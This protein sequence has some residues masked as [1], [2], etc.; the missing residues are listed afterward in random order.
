MFVARSP[1]GL[2]GAAVL[3]GLILAGPSRAQP[4]NLTPP[5]VQANGDQIC[6]GGRLDSERLAN[7][8]FYNHSDIA[9]NFK[10]ADDLRG[11]FRA[12]E[13][14]TG[15]RR[16]IVD[17]IITMT[18]TMVVQL[19][20]EFQPNVDLAAGDDTR[21]QQSIA[22][23]LAGQATP[24]VIRCKS[25]TTP[26]GP[27]VNATGAPVMPV[28]ARPPAPAPAGGATAPT[29][30]P[31]DGAASAS[32]LDQVLGNFRVRGSTDALLVARGSQA[33]GSAAAATLSLSEDGTTKTTTNALLAMIG[34][35]WHLPTAGDSL[36]DVI[37]FIGVDRN[38]TN[39][40]GQ[41]SAS[42]REN[43]MAGVVG[44]WS[45]P[46]PITFV[47]ASNVLSATYEHIWN[48][49][50]HSRLNVL[51]VVDLPVVNGYLNEYRFFPCCDTP[52]NRTWFAAS[53]LFDLR[54]DLGFYSDAGVNP[55]VNRDYQQLGS[56]FGIAVALDR[57]KS[58][59]TVSEIYLWEA[60]STRNAV[61][62]FE[63][64]WTYNFSKD[65]GLQASY[66]NGDLEATAQRIQQWLISLSV[67]Y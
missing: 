1:A 4:L 30:T 15:A 34:Y 24:L 35:D 5:T 66:Q 11:A 7:W 19:H 62:L 46:L 38:I 58:D 39:T 51:Q 18:D 47:A 6:P 13:R 26:S 29:P 54:G 53:P 43:V 33:Y 49:I 44:S 57:I 8:Y 12:P 10:S 23:F 52:I 32:A 41:Q 3:T 64:D 28:T 16:K 20:K 21:R 17:G 48:D 27:G 25:T 56:R 55:K 59:V 22:G 40:A 37:P 61:S 45:Y 2:T 14:Q 42:S 60:N 36:F 63:T 50:D 65:I 9:K 31:D 67:K